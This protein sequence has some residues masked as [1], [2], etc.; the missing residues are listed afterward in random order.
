MPASAGVRVQVRNLLLIPDAETLSLVAF[1][2]LL[3]PLFRKCSL[4]F[5]ILHL[6]PGSLA[7]ITKSVVEIGSV[8]SANT[9][10]F[11]R[12]NPNQCSGWD[13]AC[14]SYFVLEETKAHSG[15]VGPCGRVAGRHVGFRRPPKFIF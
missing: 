2:L 5:T 11:F 1:G 12:D 4:D 13:R 10:C 6:R 8:C 7:L 14:G 15:D 9:G 3:L